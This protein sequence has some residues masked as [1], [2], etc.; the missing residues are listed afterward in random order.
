MKCMKISSL[1]WILF[2]YSG[3]FDCYLSYKNSLF[4]IPV[5]AMFLPCEKNIS[6]FLPLSNLL[7]ADAFDFEGS[8]ICH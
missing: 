8:K 7:S 2:F 5:L 4:L 6:L 3:C 1:S